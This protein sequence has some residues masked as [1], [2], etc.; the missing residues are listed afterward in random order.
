MSTMP[1][2]PPQEETRRFLDDRAVTWN[3]EASGVV[4]ENG[5]IHGD[6]RWC[7]NGVTN[8]PGIPFYE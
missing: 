6:R 3:D 1:V 2:F 7:N 8:G 4:A 5:V